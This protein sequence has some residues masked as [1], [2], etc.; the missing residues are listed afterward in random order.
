MLQI[1]FILNAPPLTFNKKDLYERES[2]IRE[3]APFVKAV[4]D[5]FFLSNQFRKNHFLYYS[6]KIQGKPFVITFDGDNLRYLGPSLFSAAHLLLRVKNHILYPNSK[7]GKLT[8]GIS[9]NEQNSDWI[10]EQHSEDKF[11]QVVASEE[12]NLEFRLNNIKQSR[13]FTYGFEEL[14]SSI[15]FEKMYVK[16]LD[17]DEQVIITNYLLESEK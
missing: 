14:P 15:N 3:S 17:V 2:K 1:F 8:P 4:A 12:N 7:K 9:V 16:N 13:V 10:F 6:T 5:S 11:I